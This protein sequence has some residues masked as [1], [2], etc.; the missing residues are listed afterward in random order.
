M[1]PD[2][3][4]P[5]ETPK[6][7]DEAA[8]RIEA[9]ESELFETRGR[10]AREI[11]ARKD[12]ERGVRQS[13]EEWERTFDA[14]ED[15]VTI[16]DPEKRILRMNRAISKAF[17]CDPKDAAGAYCH[18][19]LWNR[20]L[21]CKNC[22]ATLVQEDLLPH[23]TEFE[24]RRVG[25][26]FLVS[27]SPV[28]D[29]GGNFLGIV[30]ITKDITFQKEAE[31]ALL[32]A[33]DQLEEKVRERT[34]ELDFKSG[35][36]EEA[37]T[38]LR[39]ML[40]A[41]EEDRRELEERMVS[42]LQKLVLPYLDQLRRGRMTPG[43]RECVRILDGNI[44][45]IISPFASTLSSTALNLT[46]REIQIA[47]LVKNGRTNKEMAELLGVSLRAIEF[48]RENIRGKLGLKNSKANLR[49]HLLSSY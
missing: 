41:R 7:L 23:T 3:I 6:T 46:P 33:Y 40:K 35:H 8:D 24:N 21:P 29:E 42:N 10:L 14:I 16:L 22:P 36:L 11:Q 38:A 28:F 48:H 1:I 32:K 34:A 25:K 37:N 26:H 9:L 13:R 4:H 45:E 27:A 5:K 49:S 31:K 19:V 2:S 15:Y 44:Q 30:H 43:Q 18:Q 17:N 12:T 39:M 20:S 47:N